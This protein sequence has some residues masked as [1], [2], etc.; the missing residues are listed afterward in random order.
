MK[1]L[2]TDSVVEALKDTPL[3]VRR[4]FGKQL[5]FLAADLHHPSLQAKKYNEFRGRLLKHL[6]TYG[7]IQLPRSHQIIP[8]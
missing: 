4:A 2:L 5:R 3:P 8:H 1:I 7:E 6:A